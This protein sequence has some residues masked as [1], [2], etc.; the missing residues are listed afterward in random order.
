ME[1][2]ITIAPLS[3]IT[4]SMWK[5]RTLAA[6]IKLNVFDVIQDVHN[7]KEIADELKLKIDALERLLNA[8]VAMEL[9][10]K[11]EDS[12]FNK[13]ISV[14]FLIKES[15]GYYGDFILMNEESDDSWKELDKIIINGSSII[16]NHREKLAKEGFTKA[17]HN[18]AQAPAKAISG[19]LDFSDKKHI[20]DI[21]GGSGA[22]SIILTN[23]YKDLKATVIEQQAVCKTVR[24]YIEKEG[25]VDQVSILEGDYFKVEFPIHDVAL[26]G[27]IFHSNSK[28]QNTFLLKKV[29]DKLEENG[30]VIITEFLLD[31]DKTSPL[32]PALF[33]LNMLKQ[34]KDGRAY[35]FSEIESW[36]KD[37]GFKNI[38]K[39]DL[40]GPHTAIIAYK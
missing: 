27:Q 35:T 20:L 39:Q 33:T 29:F 36:L 28:Y 16:E 4:T 34:T 13:P 3:S 32:F 21:G 37:V 38:E 30:I 14:K 17:M 1:N 9:L 19:L 8:L 23:K 40:V 25:N 6:G 22:F 15:K 24:E 18:N 31:E 7:I 11:K 26:F 5:F 2:K 10:E 12:Y